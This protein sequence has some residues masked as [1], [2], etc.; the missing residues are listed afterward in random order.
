MRAEKSSRRRSARAASACTSPSFAGCPSVTLAIGRGHGRCLAANLALGN[1][2]DAPGSARCPRRAS[3]APCVE[4]IRCACSAGVGRRAIQVTPSGEL[5]MPGPD[6]P[7]TGR[8]S[9]RPRFAARTSRAGARRWRRR[10]SWRIPTSA[11]SSRS[12]RATV[13]RPGRGRA[14]DSMKRSRWR[15]SSSGRLAEACHHPE[16]IWPCVIG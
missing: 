14:G 1:P 4:E 6:H 12:S 8:A 7:T 2:P 10:A 11:A 13:S 5:V 3:A 15:A 16:A 9:A